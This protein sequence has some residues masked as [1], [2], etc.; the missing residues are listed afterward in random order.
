MTDQEIK[1]IADDIFERYPDQ[2]KVYVTTDGQAFFVESDA[3]NHANN[4]R[5]GDQLEV[6]AFLRPFKI[7]SD[8]TPEVKDEKG[9]IALIE[10]SDNADE[11]NAIME[12][13]KAGKNRA[14]VIAAAVTRIK[15]IA[16][17]PTSLEVAKSITYATVPNQTTVEENTQNE[18]PETEDPQPES[19]MAAMVTDEQNAQING[20]GENPLSVKS[21]SNTVENSTDNPDFKNARDTIADIMVAETLDRVNAILEAEKNG[22]NRKTVIAA[23]EK[24]IND[25]QNPAQ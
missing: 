7:D 16:V 2:L 12:A 6:K 23:A 1:A 11:V 3:K 24:K 19:R 18:E 22:D 14:S 9:T 21:S 17:I 8:E 20:G 15:R 10:D 4:N 5:G 25:L 13:E